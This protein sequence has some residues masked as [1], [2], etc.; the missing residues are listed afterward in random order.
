[1]KIVNLQKKY[2]EKFF[3]VR[4]VSLTLKEGEIVSLL[5]E[6]G[7]GKSTLINILIGALSMTHG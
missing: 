5:G 3:A 2:G 7:A 4:G 1:M 6:N